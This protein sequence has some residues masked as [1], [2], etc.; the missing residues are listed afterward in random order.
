VALKAGIG[1]ATIWG[2]G[3]GAPAREAAFANGMLSHAMDFDDL[4]AASIMH[5]SAVIVPTAVALG[6]ATGAD[7]RTLLSAAIV[8][9]EVAALLG[10]MAPGPFQEHGFQSTS[11]LGAFAAAAV[12]SRLLALNARQ[13]VNALGIVGSM[14]SGLMEFLAD[15][16]DVKQMHAGWAAQSGIRAA[17]LAA[18]GFTGP[19]TVLEG[20]FGVFR[21]FARRDVSAYI[22]RQSSPSHWEV[23]DMAVKPYPACLAVHPQVQAILE[24]RKRRVIRADRLGD[25]KAIRC[26]VPRF[27]IPLVFEPASN[28]VGV[29]TPYEA[30]FSAPYCMARA[31]LDGKLDVDSFSMAKIGEADV[32]A[33]AQKITYEEADLPEFPL[34]FPA[35]VS[36]TKIDGRKHVSYVRHNLGSTGNPLTPKQL[37]IKFLNC[38]RRA[39]GNDAA[40]ALWKGVRELPNRNGEKR[41]FSAL[42]SSRVTNKA[43]AATR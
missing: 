16:S 6:E 21:S 8:G 31:L 27:Y 39:I 3:V 33:I 22:P 40:D 36:V 41:F 42:R 15:G 12:S 35:R 26:E 1:Q 43:S 9:Y 13:A 20:R 5:A 25:I 19:S 17:E 7:S 37:E 18:E 2:I 30:R 14:A 24:L 23:E 11:V 4:H 10:R 28:K 38:T 32:R 29:R 34:A